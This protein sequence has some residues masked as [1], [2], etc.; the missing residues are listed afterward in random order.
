MLHAE[1]EEILTR[2]SANSAVLTEPSSTNS[3]SVRIIT[4]R[5]LVSF[6]QL[7]YSP[8]PPHPILKPVSSLHRHV[9]PSRSHQGHPAP[10]PP[11]ELW[12]TIPKSCRFW[13]FRRT[14]FPQLQATGDTKDM[15][16]HVHQDTGAQNATKTDAR[17]PLSR[18]NKV[19]SD[20][21]GGRKPHQPTGERATAAP[22]KRRWEIRS[23]L[24]SSQ[25]R[26]SHTPKIV[27][28]KTVR[29]VK[30]ARMR[31]TKC[32]Q[33]RLQETEARASTAEKQS[34]KQPTS[35]QWKNPAKTEQQVKVAQANASR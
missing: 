21:Q 2:S 14:L 22:L 1:L 33:D 5:D 10:R 17:N 35:T 16:G 3:S 19:A 32:L 4:M 30:G 34:E 25:K 8:P 6:A 11:S 27:T 9:G 23:T 7:Q 12:A 15:A 18:C 26:E 28:L 20:P 24:L 29:D 31:H 13:S